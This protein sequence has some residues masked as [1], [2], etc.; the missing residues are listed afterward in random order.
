MPRNRNPPIRIGCRVSGRHEELE[1]P[2]PST[3]K[4]SKK[5]KHRRKKLIYGQ[6]VYSVGPN[7]YR[8][9]WD[10]CG[11]TDCK[12]ITLKYEGEGT[13]LLE[14][15]GGKSRVLGSSDDPV[16]SFEGTGSE[17]S[18]LNNVITRTSNDNIP[19][20][21]PTSSTSPSLPTLTTQPQQPRVNTA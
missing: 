18:S 3:D 2:P 4:E 7:S 5:C 1:D 12:S 21:Q 10:D 6:V 19:A 16:P 15:M 14:R 17:P 20:S 13:P 11:Y 9:L 8:V